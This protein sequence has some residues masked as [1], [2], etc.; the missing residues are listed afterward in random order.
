MTCFQ[1]AGPTGA[2][3]KLVDDDRNKLSREELG[4]LCA[5]SISKGTI[6]CGVELSEPFKEGILAMLNEKHPNSVFQL[7]RGQHG[8]PFAS[9]SNGS[10]LIGF[11][12]YDE[13]VSFLNQPLSDSISIVRNDGSMW[14]IVQTPFYRNG[15]FIECIA[16]ATF[17]QT[18]AVPDASTVTS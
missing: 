5:L 13:F 10:Q 4:F 1:T 11:R 18:R 16:N 17:R 2:Q 3:K 12:D 15:P 8:E 7:R 9:S 6:P 14:K